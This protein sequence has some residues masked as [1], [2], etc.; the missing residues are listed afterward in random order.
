M[1]E[2]DEKYIRVRLNMTR[3]TYVYDGT[4]REVHTCT[5]DWTWREVHTCTTEHASCSIVHV[6]TSRHVP[7]YTYVL[8]VMFSQSYRYV[9]LVM[10]CRTRMYFLSCD[11]KYI[12]VRRNMTRSTYVYDRTRR[13]VNTCTTEHVCTSCFVQSYPYVLLAMFRHKRMHFS[14]CI[15]VHLCTFHVQSYTCV[16]LVMFC[17][18]R[19]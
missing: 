18:T 12:R 9:L 1:T 5:T 3:S 15:F 19:M 7:S 13:E 8:L 11:E 16:L 14:S 2:H 4:W 17:R 6:C 10:F